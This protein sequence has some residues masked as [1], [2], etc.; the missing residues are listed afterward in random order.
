METTTT[1]YGN[2]QIVIGD[3]TGNVHVF[4]KDWS[5]VTFKA[6]DSPVLLSKF[7]KTNNLLVTVGEDQTE[8]CC[9]KVWNLVKSLREGQT[10]SLLRATKIALQ[11]PTAL[12]VS[13]NGQLMAIGFQGGS[14]SLY[15]GD[16]GRDR[17]KNCKSL[18]GGLSSITGL[19]FKTT[20]K[21]TLLYVCT[22]LDVLVY[23]IQGRDREVRIL[24]QTD[25]KDKPSP[26][27]CSA[28]QSSG[29]RS[30]LV[31]R[32][33]AIYCFDSE[34]MGP[35]YALDGVKSALECFRTYIVIVLR[36]TKKASSSQK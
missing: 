4:K 14:V 17:T 7:C 21:V 30:F 31:G 20:G 29:M 2:G 27:R 11:T 18:S 3:S 13:E 15:K 36:P 23:N 32:D 5:C 22:K 26:I 16:I 28:L 19:A 25:V 35:C 24:L 9:F 12:D 10:P 6:H 33:S 8:G 34:D 1:T